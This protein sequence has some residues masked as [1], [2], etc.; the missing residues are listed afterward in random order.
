MEICLQCCTAISMLAGLMLFV[1]T[2]SS[3]IP[4]SCFLIF[5]K[6]L[7]G[8]TFFFALPCKTLQKISSN[9]TE[10]SENKFHKKLHP[11]IVRAKKSLLIEVYYQDIF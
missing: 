2:V 6:H 7:K 8:P 3:A 11:I 10:N 1:Q 5:W 4:F 9:N